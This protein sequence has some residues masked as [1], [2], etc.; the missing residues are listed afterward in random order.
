YSSSVPASAGVTDTF[1]NSVGCDSIVTL[2]LTVNPYLTG[3]LDTAI[4]QGQSFVFNGVTYSTSVPPS[5]GIT[6]TIQNS[7]GCDSIVTLNLT[8]KPTSSFQLD[9][10]ICQGHTF[11]F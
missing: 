4:C 7:S 6:D 10:T 1:V 3:Q 2:N 11:T 5:M 9:T 8:V